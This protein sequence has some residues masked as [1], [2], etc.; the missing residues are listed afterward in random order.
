MTNMDILKSMGRV[1]PSAQRSYDS[2]VSNTE[3]PDW[4]K[5]ERVSKFLDARVP[6]SAPSGMGYMAVSGMDAAQKGYNEKVD[7]PVKSE[8]F[9]EKLKGRNTEVFGNEYGA[10]GSILDPSKTFKSKSSVGRLLRGEQSVGQTGLQIMGQGAGAIGDATVSGIKTTGKVA[11]AITPDFIEDPIKK[12]A[13]DFGQ[14][15]AGSEVGKSVGNAITGI[16]SFYN[17][18]KEKDPA[19]AADLAAIVNIASILPLPP[20]KTMAGTAISGLKSKLPKIALGT[21]QKDFDTVVAQGMAKGVKP[22]FRGAMATSTVAL[23]EYNMKASSA[24]KSII[25]IQDSLQYTDDAGDAIAKGKLPSNN[26]EYTQAISQAKKQIYDEYSS[27]TQAATGEG[28]TVQLDDV[29][30]KLIEYAENPVNQLSGAAKT[31]YAL[32]MAERLSAQ[33]DLNPTQVEELIQILNKSLAPSYATKTTKGVAEVDLSI[34]NIL[35]DNL[36]NVVTGSTGV[37]YQ[38]LKNAYGALKAI[39]KDVG[40][41]ALVEARKNSKGLSDLTDIFTG[42][43]VIAGAIGH[44]PALIARGLTGKGIQW[45]YKF[46]T[47]PDANIMRMFNKAGRLYKGAKEA[48]PPPTPLQ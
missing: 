35:R 23:K 15:V 43:D 37:E 32:K 45:Y 10:L 13:S 19:T 39:E 6:K 22:Q 48:I 20:L 16:V 31:K 40:H 38:E 27:A 1:V 47:S 33:G 41:R 46:A 8:S 2:I 36:D 24:V 14:F 4:Q 28:I 7:E 11:S 29:V 34:A 17:D 26:S 30:E 18:L 25:D 9:V 21:A 3:I 42:G 44:N 12:E 5:E